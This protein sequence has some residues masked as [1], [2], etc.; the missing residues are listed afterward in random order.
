ML[1]IQ[2]NCQISQKENKKNDYLILSRNNNIVQFR[3]KAHLEV[4]Q[5]SKNIKIPSVDDVLMSN[6]KCELA[7]GMN[8]TN[9]W[10][11]RETISRLKAKRSGH[12]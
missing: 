1:S 10:K 4:V 6:A 12:Y 7:T 3:K 11:V 2:H 9:Q 8:N 5:I